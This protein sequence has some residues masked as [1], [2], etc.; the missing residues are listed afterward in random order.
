MYGDLGLVPHPP[1]AI[2][3]PLLVYTD[4]IALSSVCIT[5]DTHTYSLSHAHT[6]IHTLT[7]YAGQQTH[8]TK[9]FC[10]GNIIYMRTHVK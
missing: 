3:G 9:K 4:R 1:I 5:T 10:K 6:H 2:Q 8:G 7:I